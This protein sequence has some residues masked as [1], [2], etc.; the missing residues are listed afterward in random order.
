MI[1]TLSGFALTIVSIIAFIFVIGIIIVIHELG[2]FLVA[3]KSGITCNEFSIGMGPAIYKKQFEKTLFCIRAI[4]VGGYVSMASEEVND[5]MLKPGNIIRLVLEDEL[6]TKIILDGKGDYDVKGELV[7]YDLNDTEGNGMYITLLVDD[8]EKTYQIREKAIYVLNYKQSIQVTP[9]KETFDAQPVYKRFLTMAAGPFMNFVLAIIIYF[10][11][12]CAVGVPNYNSNVIGEVGQ[13]YASEN[14]L[15]A[16]DEITYVNNTKVNSWSEFEVALDEYNKTMP[17]SVSLVVNRDGK[18][19]RLNL[20]YSI[21]INSI[22]LSNLQIDE[23]NLVEGVEGAVV[24]N[25]AITYLDSKTNFKYLL[26]NGDIITSMR[27]DVLKDKNNIIK[28]EVVPIKS[29]TDIVNNLKDVDVANIYFGYYDLDKAKE[30]PDNPYVTVD[31]SPAIRSWGNEM[32]NNQNIEKISLKLGISPTYHFHLGG[33]ITSTFKGFWKDFT[34]VFRTLKLLIAPSGIRQVGV[35]NLS[36]VVG[37]FG[38]V[39][40]IIVGGFLPLLAFT[41]LLS[42]NIGVMNLLP[43]PVLDGGKIV[44]LGYEAITRKKPNKKFENAL[45][46]IFMVLLLLLFIYVTFNDISRLIG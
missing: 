7:S 24:G 36:S 46:M 11:Y 26:T 39:Q 10:I 15:L 28:G 31:E 32:L 29:F 21:I 23:K 18:E 1:L 3:R 20:N 4:P 6:V 40:Q 43:L 8:E 13:G 34:L 30:T 16:G 41:A 42:T 19:Q 45:N 27:V 22:G 44:F 37:I 38:M 17:T 25:T 12:F 33:V 5:E 2:H 35:K 9:Y 14:V